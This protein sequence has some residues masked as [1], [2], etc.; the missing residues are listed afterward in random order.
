M[1]PT[2][3]LIHISREIGHQCQIHTNEKLRGILATDSLCN[4]LKNL[5]IPNRWNLLL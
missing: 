4:D 3:S 2:A 5:E 1:R